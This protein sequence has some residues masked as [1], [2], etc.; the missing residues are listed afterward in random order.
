MFEDG[1]R[2]V[3]RAWGFERGIWSNLIWVSV[4]SLFAWIEGGIVS[5]STVV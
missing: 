2:S 4:V 5:S 3:M 1:L